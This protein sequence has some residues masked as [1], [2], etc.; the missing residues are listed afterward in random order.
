MLTLQCSDEQYYEK[1]DTK[2]SF[3]IKIDVLNANIE[4]RNYML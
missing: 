4:E 1:Y 3:C 2:L